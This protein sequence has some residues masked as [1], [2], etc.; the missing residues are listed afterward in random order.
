MKLK[1]PALGVAAAIVTAIGFGTC[2][3]LFAIA[4]GPTAA[5]VSW[6]LHVDV[7]AM[8]RPVSTTNLLVGIVLF[9]SYVGLFVGVTAAL[10]NRISAL[11]AT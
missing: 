5:F 8:T 6:V 4:P 11:R 9:A 2:G 1:A 3:L 10:Y 7:T